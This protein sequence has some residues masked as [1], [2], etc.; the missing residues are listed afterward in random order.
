MLMNLVA[1]GKGKGNWISTAL[2][3]II[4]AHTQGAQAWITQFYH[5]SHHACLHKTIITDTE[6]CC[7]AGVFL[8][9][10]RAH[11]RT[12]PSTTL[13]EGGGAD[14]LQ[15][16]SPCLQVSARC[17]TAVYLADE[18]CQPADTEARCRRRSASASSLIAR[19]TRLSTVG[20]RAF[21]VAALR[22]WNSLPQNVTL[23]LSLAIFRSRLKT[24]LFRRCFLD[25]SVLIMPD[26]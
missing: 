17:S 4:V 20:D 13:V 16:G 23:A 19:R 26:K 21:P 24:R 22:I 6:F 11:H 5:K 7:S 10:V 12:P 18:L 2:C 1:H 15:A 14:R 9:E 8:V 25:F 3:F